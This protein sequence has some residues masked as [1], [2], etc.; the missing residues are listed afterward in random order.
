MHYYALGCIPVIIADDLRLPFARRLQWDAFSVRVSVIYYS[1]VVFYCVLGCLGCIPVIIAD[2]L[3]LPF[4]RRLQWEAFSVRVSLIYY[5]YWNTFF[6][7][8]SLVLYSCML[9]YCVLGWFL[10]IIA[11]DLMLPFARE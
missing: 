7:R 3:R 6:V 8:V 11:D 4:A 5:S 1:V 9:L 10:V 2:D